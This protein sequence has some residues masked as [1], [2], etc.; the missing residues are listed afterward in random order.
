MRTY[1]LKIGTA[2]AYASLYREEGY[3]IQKSHLGE[4]VGY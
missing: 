2:N 4:P 1:D 3:A